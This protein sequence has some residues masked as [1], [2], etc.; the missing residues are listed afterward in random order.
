MPKDGGARPGPPRRASPAGPSRG[1][2]PLACS[3]D[4]ALPVA[5]Q[6][7]GPAELGYV[8][9]LREA[10]AMLGV[11]QPLALARPGVTIVEPAV[12]RA[13]AALD[14]DPV[15]VALEGDSAIST[16]P[17]AAADQVADLRRV[18]AELPPGASPAAER[19]RR[20]L[21]R[22]ADNYAAALERDAAA[23]DEVR[24]RRVRTVLAGLRPSGRLQERVLSFLPWYAAGGDALVARMLELLGTGDPVHHVLRT[25]DL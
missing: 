9:L 3:Q 6:I 20:A 19:R 8:A 21:L 1:T 10:H 15:A 11:P 2:W 24:T 16:P 12:R 5:A 17:H 4:V 7:C 13:C 25:E 23:A 18:I 22:E 14:V